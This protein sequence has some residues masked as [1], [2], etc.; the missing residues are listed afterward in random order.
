MIWLD[1][2][3]K[4]YDWLRTRP[5]FTKRIWMLYSIA[6]FCCF[7][8]LFADYYNKEYVIFFQVPLWITSTLGHFCSVYCILR[9][10]RCDLLNSIPRLLNRPQHSV[11][12]LLGVVLIFALSLVT[13]TVFHRYNTVLDEFGKNLSFSTGWLLWFAGVGNQLFVFIEGTSCQCQM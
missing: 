2:A 11:G 12:R 10:L 4:G 13:Y 6:L 5:A 9:L 7:G 3:K 1:E 8:R